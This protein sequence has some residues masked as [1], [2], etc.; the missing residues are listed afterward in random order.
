MHNLL[1]LIP[2]LTIAEPLYKINKMK[3]VSLIFFL[4]LTFFSFSQ[5]RINKT[6]SKQTLDSIKNTIIEKDSLAVDMRIKLF[7]EIM[8]KHGRNS[9][10]FAKV[11]EILIKKDS[12]TSNYLKSIVLKYGWL[13]KSQIGEEANDIAYV[14]L[15]HSSIQNQVELLPYLFYSCSISESNWEGYAWVMDRVLIAKGH[16]QIYG[17]EA[18]QDPVTKLWEIYPVADA[19]NINKRRLKLGLLPIEESAKKRGISI[20]KLYNKVYK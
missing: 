19:K 20:K 6:I 9:D 17:K 3:I 12:L 18:Q 10:E 1:L 14:M 13:G 16:K 15:L 4:N 2:V 7:D 11:R 5:N 8:P